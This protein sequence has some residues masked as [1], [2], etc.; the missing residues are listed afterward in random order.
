MPHSHKPLLPIES[1]N[2]II[3]LV[4]HNLH[5]S[6]AFVA[7]ILQK[8]G[9]EVHFA[10][11]RFQALELLKYITPDLFIVDYQLPGMNGIELYDQLHVMEG[12]EAIPFLMLNTGH[13]EHDHE[14]IQRKLDCLRKPFHT[15]T[16]ISYI[17]EL[18]G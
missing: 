3:L 14:L 16:L 7:A 13:I 18:L 5:D 17:E 9:Y 12:L 2:K 6:F 15:D 8:T 10:T 1:R 11:E 4:E